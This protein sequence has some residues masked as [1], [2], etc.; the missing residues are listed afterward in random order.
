MTTRIIFSQVTNGNETNTDADCYH[1]NDC[2]NKR[3]LELECGAKYCQIRIQLVQD[4]YKQQHGLYNL[5]HCKWNCIY[6]CMLV[7]VVNFPGCKSGSRSN[8]NDIN[9]V[10]N[11]L[12]F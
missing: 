11:E 4:V 7:L 9:G 1:F 5:M 2:T 3:K 12:G 6:N 10:A 8:N